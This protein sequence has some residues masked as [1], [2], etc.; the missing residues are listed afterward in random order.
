[1]L[2]NYNFTRYKPFFIILCNI[3]PLIPVLSAI[4]VIIVYTQYFLSLSHQLT[5]FILMIPMN[6]IAAQITEKTAL[7]FTAFDCRR[8]LSLNSY[9]KSEWCTA[10]SNKM[11]N[12]MGDNKEKTIILTHFLEVEKLKAHI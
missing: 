6:N 5:L 7:S 2:C 3:I 9:K 12:Q 8:P 1:M 4:F 11:N 10:K